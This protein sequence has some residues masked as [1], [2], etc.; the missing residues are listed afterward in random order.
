MIAIFALSLGG[1][2]QAD[3][4]L[5]ARAPVPHELPRGSELR[6]H[7]ASAVTG[8]AELL[9]AL[10]ET[11]SGA[12][13]VVTLTALEERHAAAEDVATGLVRAYSERL[14]PP[15]VHGQRL[16]H[17][18]GGQLV[19]LGTPEQHSRLDTALATAATFHDKVRIVTRIYAGNELELPP[20]DSSGKLVLTERE[21]SQLRARLE[22][23]PHDLLNVPEILVSPWRATRLTS[24]EKTPYVQDYNVVEV[25]GLEH[26]VLDPLIA[27]LETG[28]EMSV[29]CVPGTEGKLGLHVE[30]TDRRLVRPLELFV[31]PLGKQEVPV[32]IQL[33][34]TRL[35]G[36]AGHFDL[37]EA[38][39]LLLA[40]EH[41]KE[42]VAVL[43]TVHRMRDEAR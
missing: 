13:S 8:H 11:S 12:E 15:L 5:H 28:I 21:A 30:L 39:T 14:E 35:I 26:E 27:Q 42:R 2:W 19:L 22:T 38:E 24:L 36:L 37:G 18:G 31:L 32:T 25:P 7:D 1:L 9:R 29:L 41:D 10:L 43:I 33:P 17:L 4:A 23:R 40:G 20:L 34:E 16:L 3:G 6:A